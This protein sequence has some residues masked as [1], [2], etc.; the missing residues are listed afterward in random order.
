MKKREAG[1]NLRVSIPP[2]LFQPK[3]LRFFQAIGL[4]FIDIADIL[5]HLVHAFEVFLPAEFL[6]RVVNLFAAVGAFTAGKGQAGGKDKNQEPGFEGLF[7]PCHGVSPCYVRV[8][9]SEFRG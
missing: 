9:S 8:M 2:T 5:F 1:L 7:Y 6:D 4:L 3:S